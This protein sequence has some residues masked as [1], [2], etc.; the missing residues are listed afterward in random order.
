MSRFEQQIIDWMMAHEQALFMDGT[1]IGYAARKC[2]EAL[3]R[4]VSR[5]RM[6]RICKHH[7]RHWKGRAPMLAS[8][9]S[10]TW[11]RW[12]VIFD[13]VRRH[14]GETEDPLLLARMCQ[15]D[16]PGG[17]SLGAI[18]EALKHTQF[19]EETRT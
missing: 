2:S 14:R 1:S 8:T 9:S 5:A 4:K 7:C 3:G 10:H 18:K 19:Q 11:R 16:G 6:S 17:V 13:W 12:Q 15:R